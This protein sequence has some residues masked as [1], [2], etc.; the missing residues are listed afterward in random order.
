PG[1][2][3]TTGQS[4]FES[5]STS[6][7]ITSIDDRLSQK[8]SSFVFE[9]GTVEEYIET[10]KEIVGEPS[11]NI[12]IAENARRQRMPKVTLE[13]VT[14]KSMLNLIQEL[15]VD[16][17]DNSLVN[18]ELGSEFDREYIFIRSNGTGPQR[19]VRVF[20]I[21]GLKELKNQVT[22]ETLLKAVDSVMAMNDSKDVQIQIHGEASLLIA[23]GTMEELDLIQQTI[24]QMTGRAGFSGE[25]GSGMDGGGIGGGRGGGGMGG[26]GAGG[27]PF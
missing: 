10:L 8:V 25:S 17:D 20:S 24:G 27:A 19:I 5:P 1:T 2:R 7:E 22:E 14:T 11:L 26:G 16:N 13:N 21:A 4:I 12:V 15:C 9:G 3:S 6:K 23:K 18:V